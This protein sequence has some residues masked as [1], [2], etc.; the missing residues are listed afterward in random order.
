MAKKVARKRTRVAKKATDVAQGTLIGPKGR[1][2][3]EPKYWTVK[4]TRVN[5]DDPYCGRAF[6]N[7]KW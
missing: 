7:L 5:P 2:P 4:V 1:T 6:L 3:I